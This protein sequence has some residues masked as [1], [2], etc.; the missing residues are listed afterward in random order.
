MIAGVLAGILLF[1][2]PM[3]GCFGPVRL[4]SLALIE[5]EARLA[6][7]PGTRL[8]AGARRYPINTQIWAVLEVPRDRV[9]PMLEGEPFGGYERESGRPR[10][11]A[12]ITEHWGHRPGFV[13]PLP[14]RM[15]PYLVAT[16]VWREGD[17]H[18]EFVTVVVD[19]SAAQADPV[20]VYLA[21]RR[22]RSD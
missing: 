11:S 17:G 14:D 1:S 18:G 12:L 5:R 2:D 6:L 8:V 10:P 16:H 21:C 3:A 19:L 9:R 22:L 4:T 15:D 13:P 7:P 20:P